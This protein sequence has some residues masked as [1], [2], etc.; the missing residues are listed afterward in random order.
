[1]GALP[2]PE[3]TNAPDTARDLR[4]IDAGVF[5]TLNIGGRLILPVKATVG[6]PDDPVDGL[7][8]V[9]LF[10]NTVRVYWGST[11]HTLTWS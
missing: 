2:L 11:W 3:G 4:I 7:M 9:N 10:S 6:D 8:Y 5:G 1:M